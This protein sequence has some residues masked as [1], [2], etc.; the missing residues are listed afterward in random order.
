MY[1]NKSYFESN[2]LRFVDT[3]KFTYLTDTTMLQHSVEHKWQLRTQIVLQRLFHKCG[4]N[5]TLNPHK[6]NI[7]GDLHFRSVAFNKTC[8]LNMPFGKMPFAKG[9][10]KNSQ[11]L[12][13]CQKNISRHEQRSIVD[14]SIHKTSHYG[15]KYGSADCRPLL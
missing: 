7:V 6:Y 13:K 11:S 3:E 5:Q 1:T 15:L 14:S 9:D 2:K 10:W 12:Q 8:D 4:L